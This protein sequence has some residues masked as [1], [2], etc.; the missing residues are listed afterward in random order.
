MLL[1]RT[2]SK[3]ARFYSPCSIIFCSAVFFSA[4]LCWAGQ[5]SHTPQREASGTPEARYHYCFLQSAELTNRQEC[6]CV[7]LCVH[8]CVCMRALD[9]KSPLTGGLLWLSELIANT[10]APAAFLSVHRDT[11]LSNKCICKHTYFSTL[12]CTH[13]QIRIL[14]NLKIKLCISPLYEDPHT[15]I[16]IE[17]IQT[18]P[19]ELWF[20]L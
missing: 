7:C 8:V 4:L 1:C 3:S 14:F 11:R 16:L 10:D 17:L 15:L 5:D 13:K 20:S 18:L 2:V 9:P 6:I 12:T 19:T